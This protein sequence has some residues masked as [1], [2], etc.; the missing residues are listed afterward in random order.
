MIYRNKYSMRFW[1]WN[2]L[3]A[4]LAIQASLCKRAGQVK[5]RSRSNQFWA[6]IRL[7]NQ[8]FRF[9][10]TLCAFTL[11]QAEVVDS[12]HKQIQYNN[13]TLSFRET[14]ELTILIFNIIFIIKDHIELG[15]KKYNDLSKKIKISRPEYYQQKILS[16]F[17]LGSNRIEILFWTPNFGRKV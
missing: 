13:D 1:L 2:M 12:L 14:L 5:L 11:F 7:T 4:R 16:N 10:R 9:C 17:I 8:V 6:K 3:S 15:L